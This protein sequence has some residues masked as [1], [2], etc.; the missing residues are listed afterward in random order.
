MTDTERLDVWMQERGLTKK[1]LAA[2][3]GVKYI[4]LWHMTVKR[5]TVSDKFITAFIRHFGC[6][7]AVKV[8]ADALGPADT[9][10]A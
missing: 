9:K 4:T 6:D 10:I 3:M 1:S 2:T 7:E 5:K 8:F